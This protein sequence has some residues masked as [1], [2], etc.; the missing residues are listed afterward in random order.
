MSL[1]SGLLSASISTRLLG[2]HGPDLYL[3]VAAL[4][5]AETAILLGFII[6]GETAALVGGAV[7]GLHHAN[8]GLMI[9]V[10]I[11]AAIA[12]DSVGYLVGKVAGP[13]ILRRRPLAGNR[14]VAKGQ[15]LLARFGGPAVFLGRWVALARALVPGLTGMS[16]VRYRIFLIF[17]VLGGIAW[18]TTYVLLGYA[19]GASYPKV[20]KVAGTATLIIIGAVVVLIVVWLAIRRHK[21]AS[22]PS[23]LGKVPGRDV[24]LAANAPLAGEQHEV[25]EGLSEGG[26]LHETGDGVPGS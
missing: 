23:G 6:P 14:G 1:G 21:A 20:A 5:F 2:I 12:G 3:V 24:S 8:V 19:A 26:A 22:A 13:A 11:G 25:G 17:N 7:A 9:V 16:A 4:V 15:E 18:G 10:V